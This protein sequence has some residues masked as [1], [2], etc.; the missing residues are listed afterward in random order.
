MPRWRSCR[1][2]LLQKRL[3][4]VCP[5]RTLPPA[6]AH[7]IFRALDARAILAVAPRAASPPF[8]SLARPCR[9][10]SRR[11]TQ[12][13]GYTL[14]AFVYPV[15]PHP[16]HP[17]PLFSRRSRFIRSLLPLQTSDHCLCAPCPSAFT[18]LRLTITSS[19]RVSRFISIFGRWLVARSNTVGGGVVLLAPSRS[20][21]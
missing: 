12:P 10:L 14:A 2:G 11:P 18:I 9:R 1:A 3:S 16:P 8:S 17:R 4:T 19:R 6:L 7:C 21:A 13:K 15:A 5:R 20:T